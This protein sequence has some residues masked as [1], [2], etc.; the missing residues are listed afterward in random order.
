MKKIKPHIN[1]YCSFCKAA[2]LEK[3]RAVW[4][5]SYDRVNRACDIHR[6][7]LEA[8]ETRLRALDG[9]PS[10]ADQQTWMKL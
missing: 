8:F 3:V 9:D 4:R 7:D 5:L 2:G 6:P 10:E 1:T